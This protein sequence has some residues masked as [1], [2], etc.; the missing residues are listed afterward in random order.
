MCKPEGPDMAAKGGWSITRPTGPQHG[1]STG[2][3]SRSTMLQDPRPKQLS[4]RSPGRGSGR[5]ARMALKQSPSGNSHVRQ[6]IRGH[7]DP[8]RSKADM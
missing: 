8:R 4:Y 3:V 1:A 2:S 5:A 6:L 7:T